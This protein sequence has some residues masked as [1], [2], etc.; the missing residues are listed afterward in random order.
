VEFDARSVFARVMAFPAVRVIAGMSR[1]EV[2]SAER[3][4]SGLKELSL[5]HTN[6]AFSYAEF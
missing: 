1:A 2:H 5:W 6:K 4:I 3:E